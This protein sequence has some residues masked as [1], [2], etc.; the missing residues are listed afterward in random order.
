MRI[1]VDTNVVVSALLSPGGTPAKLL[2]YVVPTVALA[3]VA[4]PLAIACYDERIL[5]EYR[6]VLLRPKFAERI[7]ASAV[8][9][10]VSAFE[11][12]GVRMAAPVSPAA[13]VLLDPGDQPFLDV[14][15]AARVDAIVT[16]N[17]RHFP[18]ECGVRVL[19]PSGLL[20]LLLPSQ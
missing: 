19:T 20:A 1:V 14:A 7:A 13:F 15:V 9:A 16:G 11:V 18:P 17:T 6:E 3:T 2:D 10:V 5:A 12:F 8:S 4:R